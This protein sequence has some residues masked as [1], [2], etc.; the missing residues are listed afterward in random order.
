[1]IVTRGAEFVKQTCSWPQRGRF[2]DWAFKRLK[3][4]FLLFVGF[5]AQAFGAG[6]GSYVNLVVSDS[7]ANPPRNGVRVTYLGTNGY[8]FEFKDHALLVDPY[9]S[10]VDLLSVAVGSKTL[11]ISSRIRGTFLEGVRAALAL[12]ILHACLIFDP[13]APFSGRGLR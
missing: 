5:T 8:Q 11:A 12:L 3:R 13:L 9:F 6:L 1:M 10:R 7:P 4:A 2:I